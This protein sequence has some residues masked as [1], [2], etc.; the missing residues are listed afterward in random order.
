MMLGTLAKDHRATPSM[1]G[2]TVQSHNASHAMASHAAL[3]GGR[4]KERK[5]E[6][7]KRKKKAT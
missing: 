5:K 4:G 7:K 2:K 6:G 1:R 3:A